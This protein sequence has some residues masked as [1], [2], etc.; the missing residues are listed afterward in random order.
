[1]LNRFFIICSSSKLSAKYFKFFAVCTIILFSNQTIA[2]NN[3]DTEVEY[4]EIDTQIEPEIEDRIYNVSTLRNQPEYPGGMRRFYMDIH[5]S[6]RVPEGLTGVYKV[7]VSFVIEIDGTMSDIKISRDPGHGIGAEAKRV[8]ENI[9]KKWIVAKIDGE[10]VRSRHI[11]P[12]NID[13]TR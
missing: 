10:P 8:L 13:Y 11:L 7:Y 9:D 4:D 6:F 1:V 2:Q 3:N 5:K 12:I